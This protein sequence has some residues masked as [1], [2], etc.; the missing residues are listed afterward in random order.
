MDRWGAREGGR[1]VLDGW[2]WSKKK[3]R[4]LSRYVEPISEIGYSANF[5]KR[6][7][8]ESSRWL[9]STPPRVLC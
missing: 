6:D 3:Q 7:V 4:C 1:Y 2:L 8:S 5:Q 9:L